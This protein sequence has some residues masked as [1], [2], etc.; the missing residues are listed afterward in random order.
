[1]TSEHLTVL[2]LIYQLSA[3]QSIDCMQ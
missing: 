3:Y 2:V 1:M